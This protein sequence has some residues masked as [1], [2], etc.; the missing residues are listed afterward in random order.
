MKAT[1][2]GGPSHP[3]LPPSPALK[4][5]GAHPLPSAPSHIRFQVPEHRGQ[6]SPGSCWGRMQALAHW[7]WVQVTTPL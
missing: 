1:A 3:P 5:G 4:Q 7:T 2:P 6:Q